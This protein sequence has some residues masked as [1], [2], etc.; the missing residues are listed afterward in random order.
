[1]LLYLP[2]YHLVWRFG[3]EGRKVDGGEQACTEGG[4]KPHKKLFEMVGALVD[5]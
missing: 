1:M 4:K 3:S 5:P 2:S